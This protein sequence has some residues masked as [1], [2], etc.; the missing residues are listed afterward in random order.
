M[1]VRADSGEVSVGVN[2]GNNCEIPVLEP[3]DSDAKN[4]HFQNIKLTVAA[5]PDNTIVFIAAVAPEIASIT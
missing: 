4:R 1:L 3:E 5:E 2:L